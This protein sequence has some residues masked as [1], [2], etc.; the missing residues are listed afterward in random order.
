MLILHLSQEKRMTYHRNLARNILTPLEYES[1]LH[2][3]AYQMVCT[4]Y[5]RRISGIHY[6]H[7]LG[8]KTERV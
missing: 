3:L 7:R 5:S 8:E 2:A 4:G 1:I 6:A